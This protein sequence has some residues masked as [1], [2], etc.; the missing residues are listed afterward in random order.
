[1]LWLGFWGRWI[2]RMQARAQ[3]EHEILDSMM[4]LAMRP[5]KSCLPAL[6]VVILRS[7]VR[8]GYGPRPP[9]GG[10][11]C[12]PI[13]K[14]AVAPV[15]A[16]LSCGYGFGD[17]GLPECRRELNW[18]MKLLT[19]FWVWRCDLSKVCNC[20]KFDAQIELWLW[21]WGPRIARMQTRAQ[22]EHEIID[23]M[24]GLAMRPFKSVQLSEI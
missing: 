14:L 21:F 23:S 12:S 6:S 5:F 1:M 3:L 16:E 22:L 8:R 19:V 20:L 7:S 15:G 10:T 2:A 4:G 11:G 9:S 17:L 18:S 24:M 13:F